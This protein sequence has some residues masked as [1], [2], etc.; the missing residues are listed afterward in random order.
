MSAEIT[1]AEGGTIAASIVALIG[2]TIKLFRFQ[3]QIARL[4]SRVIDLEEKV[5]ASGAAEQDLSE[6]VKSAVRD[7]V[8]RAVEALPAA[9]REGAPTTQPS[10]ALSSTEALDR[11]VEAKVQA[12]VARADGEQNAKIAGI[13]DRV[14]D[15]KRLV[16]I[17][18]EAVSKGGT[19]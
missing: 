3:T 15:V 7:E 16:E 10:G 2:G 12:H 6:R 1:P 17:V 5:K 19:R 11:M 8:Q 9:D 13:A 4:R 14:S 18:V